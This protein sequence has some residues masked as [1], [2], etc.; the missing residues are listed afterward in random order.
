MSVPT[1]DEPPISGR[2][3]WYLAPGGRPVP[4]T[5]RRAPEGCFY[6]CR[7]G[8]RSWSLLDAFPGHRDPGV[9][10]DDDEGGA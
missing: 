6:Q 9:D 7:E 1:P 5:A 4:A 3:V 10:R 8:D 2:P